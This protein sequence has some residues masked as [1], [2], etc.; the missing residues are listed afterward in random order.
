MTLIN[1]KLKKNKMYNINLYLKQILQSNHF[2][3]GITE[4]LYKKLGEKT[5]VFN[6]IRMCLLSML[7]VLVEPVYNKIQF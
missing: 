4:V 1:W 6:Y 7:N 2:T 5:N 3:Y